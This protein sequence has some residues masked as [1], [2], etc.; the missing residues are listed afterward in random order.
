MNELDL[1]KIIALRKTLA[2]ILKHLMHSDAENALNDCLLLTMDFFNADRAYIGI[3]N[4]KEKTISFTNKI[5]S[6]ITRNLPANLLDHVTTSEMPWWINT[7]L[8]G[9]DIVISDITEMPV[10]ASAE[11][12]LITEN[13]AKS[14][15]VV[16]T[17]IDNSVNGF[18]GVE[19]LNN[20]YAWRMTDIE[21]LHIISN[22]FS[23]TIERELAVRN[24]QLQSD[25]TKLKMVIDTGNSFIWEYD[26]ENDKII[27][28]RRLI[29]EQS[30]K[31]NKAFI[32]LYQAT[33]SNQ[34][35]FWETL[36]P[37]DYDRVYN[38]QFV[39]LINGDIN[40]YSCIYRRIFEG[41]VYWF[42]AYARIMKYNEAG[43]PIRTVCYVT[44]ITEERERE[45]E[46][47]HVKEADQLKTAFLANMSH[48]IRTPL[49]AIVGFSQIITEM[50]EDKEM[51]PY[52]DIIQKNNNLL[53]QLI[54]DILDFTKLESGILN[55]QLAKIEAKDVC[56][57]V[58][59]TYSQLTPP[60]T[61][62]FFDNSLSDISIWTD[63][64]LIKQVISGF[65]NNAIKFTQEGS[66]TLSYNTT[67]KENHLCFFV[68]DTGIGISDKDLPFVF[69]RFF[70]A[71]SFRQ[72]TGL[73]LTVCKMIIHLLGGEIGVESKIG[74]GSTFWF[75]LPLE[76][77]CI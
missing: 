2:E 39:H 67:K 63:E 36:H 14:L 6:P 45:L 50:N 25:M 34:V 76:N 57:D 72:G 17:I 75:T 37:D 16:P 10:S 30:G 58:I 41:K 13:G 20:P 69:D 73:G 29:N 32:S 21:N 12:K 49:N 3:V 28:D 15:L 44:D 1:K 24:E 35:H 65:I 31:N 42:N 68:T 27:M 56:Q 61:K 74:Q 64:K 43:K 55:S 9:R 53:L 26:I 54:D 11:Q 40:S 60:G 22:I 70:K 46:L 38:Q 47:I 18:I 66:I 59:Y 52:I 33:N 77:H 19:C 62:L 5:S 51:Q 8:S 4:N 71:D 48:E 23:I 7:I